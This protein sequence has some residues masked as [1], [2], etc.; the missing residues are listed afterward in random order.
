M[1]WNC[2][3]SIKGLPDSVKKCFQERANFL[4]FDMEARRYEGKLVDLPYT[5]FHAK[6]K[7]RVTESRNPM[8]YSEV[9]W[10]NT[11]HVA[12][13]YSNKIRRSRIRKTLD[14]GR[15]SMALKRISDAKDKY[16]YR[17]HV[18]MREV[19]LDYLI[20]GVPVDDFNIGSQV[21][22]VGMQLLIEPSNDVRLFFGKEKVETYGDELLEFQRK[23]GNVGEEIFFRKYEK[24]NLFDESKEVQ[25]MRND[26][27]P[28]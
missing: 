9:Y 20:E 27:I 15:I 5:K 25:K 16:H 11:P 21:E 22:M 12:I 14:R 6:Q 28:F 18:L 24:G 2:E 23:Y 19:V 4:H 26:D 8:W 17:Y 7:G 13:K 3:Y 1:D 10:K